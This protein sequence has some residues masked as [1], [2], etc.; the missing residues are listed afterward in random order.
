LETERMASRSLI[1]ER[2]M[3]SALPEYSSSAMGTPSVGTALITTIIDRAA[4]RWEAWC[5]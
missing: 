3:I 5:L 1:S 4:D 2:P